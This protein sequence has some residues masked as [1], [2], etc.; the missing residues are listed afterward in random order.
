MDRAGK[1]GNKTFSSYPIAFG[2]TADRGNGCLAEQTALIVKTGSLTLL[3]AILFLRITDCLGQHD[4][5]LWTEFHG[6]GQ[7]F[8]IDHSSDYG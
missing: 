1:A 7:L 5:L 6:L 3:A 8:F 2:L 4:M